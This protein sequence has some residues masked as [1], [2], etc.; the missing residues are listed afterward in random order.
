MCPAVTSRAEVN[1]GRGC[2]RRTVRVPQPSHRGCLSRTRLPSRQIVLVPGGGQFFGLSWLSETWPQQPGEGLCRT[3][4]LGPMAG[5]WT[6]RKDTR[7]GTPPDCS[8]WCQPRP[9]RGG[10]ICPALQHK[11][12]LSLKSSSSTPWPAI[13]LQGVCLLGI[14]AGA[15][16][17][18]GVSSRW[19]RCGQPQRNRTLP[20]TERHSCHSMASCLDLP[21][22]AHSQ[23]PRASLTPSSSST[24]L[25]PLPSPSSCLPLPCLQV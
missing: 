13:L 14:P 3:A 11:S 6:S 24:P 2:G 12:L 25:S 19:D 20:P 7:G 1:W 9:L 4:S 22:A 10:G 5:S 18:K 16:G 17:A 8:W 21:Q 15:P 23:G